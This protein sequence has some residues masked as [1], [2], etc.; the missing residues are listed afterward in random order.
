M[1]ATD[2]LTPA[3]QAQLAD[4]I[5]AAGGREVCFVAT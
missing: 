3:V 1:H 5:A 4:E 2:R